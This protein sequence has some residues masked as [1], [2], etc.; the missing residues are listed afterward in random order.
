MWLNLKQESCWKWDDFRRPVLILKKLSTNTFIWIPLSTKLKN[1]T[2]Y[3]DYTQNWEKCTAL[4]YQ[5]K[6]FDVTRFQRRIWQMD[7]KD[8]SGIKKRLKLLLNL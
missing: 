7:E 4:L 2:W 3:A 5:I 1:G 8:F 6:M